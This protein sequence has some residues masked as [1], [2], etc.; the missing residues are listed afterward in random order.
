[1]PTGVSGSSP[2]V[3]TGHSWGQ[4]GAELG[5]V[6]VVLGGWCMGTAAGVTVV[7]GGWS[8]GGATGPGAWDLSKGAGHPCQVPGAALWGPSSCQG[9]S[10]GSGAAPLPYGCLSLSP[11]PSHRCGLPVGCMV[12]QG[13]PWL[14]PVPGAVLVPALT[15]LFPPWQPRAAWSHVLLG[16]RQ[17]MPALVNKIPRDPKIPRVPCWLLGITTLAVK[18]VEVPCARWARVDRAALQVWG[19]CW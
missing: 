14:C 5:E 7:W 8:N 15:H 9:L 6:F 12:P 11:F 1:M 13:G 3:L 18:V 4:A 19:L 2:K 16:H 17:G 10:Q